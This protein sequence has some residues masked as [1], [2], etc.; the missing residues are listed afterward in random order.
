[1]NHYLICFKGGSFEIKARNQKVFVK[2]L[3]VSRNFDLE[4]LIELHQYV[5]PE[6][7]DRLVQV[8]GHEEGPELHQVGQVRVVLH[9]RGLKNE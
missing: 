2:L 4:D 3:A 9:G 6:L 7:S 1:V 8:E 5:L